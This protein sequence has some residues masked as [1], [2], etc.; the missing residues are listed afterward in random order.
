MTKLKLAVILFFVDGYAPTPKDLVAAQQ[1]GGDIKFRNA[2][3]VDVSVVEGLE[4][5]DGVAGAV[6]A[7]YA[8]AYPKAEEVLAKK[9][10]EFEALSKKVGDEP[11]PTTGGK[12]KEKEGEG[13][14]P[15][16]PGWKAN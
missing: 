10:A 9:K 6:P 13:T 4:E 2:R 14:Q 8:A 5:C 7:N 11:A 12:Q 15:S 1:L 3:M 16:G